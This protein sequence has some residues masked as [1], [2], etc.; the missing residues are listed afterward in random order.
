[1]TTCREGN[2]GIVVEP[3]VAGLGFAEAGEGACRPGRSGQPRDNAAPLEEGTTEEKRPNKRKNGPRKLGRTTQ[4]TKDNRREEGEAGD[5][6][7]QALSRTPRTDRSGALTASPFQAGRTSLLLAQE[8]RGSAGDGL[9]WPARRPLVFG[10][11]L[12]A[13]SR[14]PSQPAWPPGWRAQP[15]KSNTPRLGGSQGGRGAAW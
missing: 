5:E 4:K 9:G 6:T 2:E 1:M 10:L 13:S 12:G 11:R 8:P 15:S 14:W 7:R 3:D